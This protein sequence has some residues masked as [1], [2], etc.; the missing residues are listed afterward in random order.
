[1]SNTSALAFY[2][3]EPLQDVVR[4]PADRIATRLLG[5]L[6][7]GTTIAAG[8]NAAEVVRTKGATRMRVCA[9]FSGDG[10]GKLTLTPV[11]ADDTSLSTNNLVASDGSGAAGTEIALDFE[12]YGETLLQ[13][14]LEED[15]ASDGITVTYVDVFLI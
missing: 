9:N 4:Q 13:V 1:M 7:A 15:G 2:E 3:G 5:S 8:E 10:T 6:A 12:L 11:L 14:K